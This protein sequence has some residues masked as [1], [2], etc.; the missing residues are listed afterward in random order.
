M[1]M[2]TV[3]SNID[4]IPGLTVLVPIVFSEYMSAINAENNN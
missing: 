1:G 3:Q 4:G 2:I